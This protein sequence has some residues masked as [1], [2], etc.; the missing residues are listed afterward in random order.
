MRDHPERYE[1]HDEDETHLDT[2]QYLSRVWHRMGEQPTV[3]HVT[4]LCLFAAAFIAAFAFGP[5]LA[6][7][8]RKAVRKARGL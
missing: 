1:L 8:V 7:R 3:P 4:E 6:E 2:T 5:G